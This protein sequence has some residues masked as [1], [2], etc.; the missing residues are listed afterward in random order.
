MLVK[1]SVVPRASDAFRKDGDAWVNNH[2][3]HIVVMKKPNLG[4]FSAAEFSSSIVDR[5]YELM[6]KANP[7]YL[8]WT[9]IEIAAKLRHTIPGWLQAIPQGTDAALL[10]ELSS[11]RTEARDFIPEHL[12]EDLSHMAKLHSLESMDQENCRPEHWSNKPYVIE[13][14]TNGSERCKKFV[15]FALSTSGLDNKDVVS[16]HQKS[17]TD[18]PTGLYVGS[19]Q[20]FTEFCENISSAPEPFPTFGA[21]YV[22][23][24]TVDVAA[25][26]GEASSENSEVYLCLSQE[27]DAVRCVSLMLL[28]GSVENAS[29]PKDGL[30]KLSLGG[31]VFGFLSEA[32]FLQSVAVEVVGDERQLGK[33][34]KIGQL[35]MATARRIRKRFWNHLSRSA[36]NLPRFTL[37][38]RNRE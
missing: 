30:T 17:V 33:F 3:T 7:D 15:H 11:E 31:N 22:H 19:Q 29:S 1:E 2:G 12:L 16:I 20:L 10:S 8:H 28:Q 36:V 34:K 24:Q 4:A 13:Q 21:V 14:M 32:E 23:E 6:S 18:A 37:K 5:I 25:G 26:S 9:A 35:R 38:D 27:C